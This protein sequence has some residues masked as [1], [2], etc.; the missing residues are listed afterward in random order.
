M[1]RW[2]LGGRRR[3]RP[4][5]PS[6]Q[7][8]PPAAPA[9]DANDAPSTA[10]TRTYP[11]PP[12]PSSLVSGAPGPPV[13]PPR[14]PPSPPSAPGAAPPTPTPVKPP[15]DADQALS[16]TADEVRS[17]RR[18]LLVVGVWSVAATAIA[19]LAF[20][21]ASDDDDQ[22]IADSNA[23]AR[24]IQR[25]VERQVTELESRLAAV[26][27]SSALT[28][29]ERRVRE[30]GEVAE[31]QDRT[32]ANEGRAIRQLQ[33]A[34]ERLRESVSDLQGAVEEDAGAAP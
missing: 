28:A 34:V 10:P 22:R 31:R 1:A 14:V 26:P 15:P 6:R 12:P 20:L 23:Q 3:G 32:D 9:R 13:Y 5:L 11:P 17:L 19:V 21:A 30:L 24:R 4:I 8:P 7:P 29:L 33:A 18:W 2:P 25:Q 16:A 27:T